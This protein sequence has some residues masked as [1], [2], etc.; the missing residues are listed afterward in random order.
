MPE[1]TPVGSCSLGMA[2]YVPWM[3][4]SVFQ[5]ETVFSTCSEA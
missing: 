1:K 5:L 2:L 4:K 3:V